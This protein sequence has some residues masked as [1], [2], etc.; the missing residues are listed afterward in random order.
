MLEI[1]QQRAE[2]LQ[3]RRGLAWLVAAPILAFGFV[4]G[5]TVKIVKL[6]WAAFLV[7]FEAGVKI[8]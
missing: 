6:A 3:I 4:V 1:I 5:V 7:G 2:Q 8:G